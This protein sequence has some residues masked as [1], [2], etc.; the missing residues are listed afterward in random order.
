MTFRC[1]AESRSRGEQL[2]GTA[3][4]VTRFVLLEHSGSWGQDA[5]RDSR[6]PART[7]AWLRRC[8]E[9]GWRPVLIR[10]MPGNPTRVYTCDER[11]LRTTR[12][13]HPH[14]AA[15]LEPAADDPWTAAPESLFLVCTHGRHDA[16][17]AERGRPLWEALRHAA[18]D[19][20]WQVSHIGGDR[21]AANVLV[22]P[23]GLYYGRLGPED[24]AT[25]VRAHRLGEL[26]LEH[27]RGRSRWPFVVQA[28]EVFLRRELGLT[29]I[30]GLDLLAVE[31][32]RVRFGVEGGVFEV[33]LGVE[34]Q[35]PAQLTCRA[36]VASVDTWFEPLEIRRQA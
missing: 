33:V 36:P 34:H 14:D 15:D 32:R 12:V 4:T 8:R 28:A 22:L 31:G 2:A 9:G 29:G 3:S 10:G 13:S 17:C 19:Q 6:V 30:D 1:S 16:C 7:K 20:T 24:A 18:P 11:G 5:I 23:E 26:D 21:F 35:A 25:L 27:L